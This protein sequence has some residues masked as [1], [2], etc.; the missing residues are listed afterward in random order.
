MVY[1][2]DY[3]AN[4]VQS[5]LLAADFASLNLAQ[6]AYS[7]RQ[8]YHPHTYVYTNS[9]HGGHN[10]HGSAYYSPT[11]SQHSERSAAHHPTYAHHAAATAAK[12]PAD[13][14]NPREY[15]FAGER[16]GDARRAKFFVIKSYSRE[17]V[18]HSIRH[19]IWCST[20][21][22]NVRLNRAFDERAAPAVYLFFSVNSSGAFCGCAEMLSRVDF[23]SKS[24]L[25]TQDKWKGK[26]D[27]KWIYVKV[28][29]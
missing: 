12:D 21:S 7:G 17:D 27:V 18:V 23:E 14:Y 8:A 15:E 20:E 5:G 3:Y 6:P 24:E 9:Q 16:E 19:G 26:F 22:G 11:S 28:S 1:P 4:L 2:G 13:K 25:W 10:G 29:G